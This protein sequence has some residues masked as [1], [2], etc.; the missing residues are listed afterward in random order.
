MGFAGN[1]FAPKTT[2]FF[3]RE[4]NYPPALSMTPLWFSKQ[5]LLKLSP[6]VAMEP[7][8]SIGDGWDPWDPS[9]LFCSKRD[10]LRM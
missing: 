3:S 9:P 10:E 7:G 5:L 8:S 2:D 4:E 1:G 6:G